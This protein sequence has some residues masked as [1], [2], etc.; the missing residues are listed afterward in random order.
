[1]TDTGEFVSFRP[2]SSDEKKYNIVQLLPCDIECA[3]NVLKEKGYHIRK[4]DSWYVLDRIKN[5]NNYGYYLF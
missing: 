3:W 2:F 4:S 1:L 5:N